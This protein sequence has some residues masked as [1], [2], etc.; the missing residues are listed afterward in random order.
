MLVRCF[1]HLILQGKKFTYIPI[2]DNTHLKESTLISQNLYHLTIN[3][4]KVSNML[5]QKLLY[6]NTYN[7]FARNGMEKD[8]KPLSLHRS[9]T[10]SKT[11]RTSVTERVQNLFRAEI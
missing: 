11:Q 5:L 4:S 6:I 9:H 7:K 1:Q 10:E 3:V 2:T 8:S